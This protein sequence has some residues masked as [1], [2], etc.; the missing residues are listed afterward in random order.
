MGQF[1]SFIMPGSLGGDEVLYARVAVT[2][3]VLLGIYFSRDVDL[4]SL[5]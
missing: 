4:V 2:I 1:I 3:A 5:G